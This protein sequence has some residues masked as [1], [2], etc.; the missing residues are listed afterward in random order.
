MGGFN[1]QT[2]QST[3]IGPLHGGGN[4]LHIVRSILGEGVLEAFL[5]HS[6]ETVSVGLQMRE[7]AD[8]VLRGRIPELLL[9][10]RRK[11]EQQYTLQL[12]EA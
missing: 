8:E 12:V 9:T 11:R 2:R 10:L 3:A 4:R 1:T 6:D 5:R 7:P